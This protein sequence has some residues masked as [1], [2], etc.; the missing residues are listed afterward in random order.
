MANELK[1]AYADYKIAKQKSAPGSKQRRAALEKIVSLGGAKDIGAVI[2]HAKGNKGAG[3]KK[4]AK[5]KAKPK[6]KKAKVYK[7]SAPKKKAKSGTKKK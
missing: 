7:K 6:A 4:K 2:S 1:K 5:P 3:A